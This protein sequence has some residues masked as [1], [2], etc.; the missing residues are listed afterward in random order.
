MHCPWDVILAASTKREL[1]VS[2]SDAERIDKVEV[3]EEVDGAIGVEVG[4]GGVAAEGIYEIEVVEE[5]N[6]SIAIEIGWT[7]GEK[8]GVTGDGAAGV[9]ND[10]AV[11][12]GS[13]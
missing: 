11:I 7:D 3:V 12:A 2:T 1:V 9:C 5:V 8:S 4:G 10:A 13:V 6:V